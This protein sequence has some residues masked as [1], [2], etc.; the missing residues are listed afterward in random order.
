MNGVR[1]L[2]VVLLLEDDL[3]RL[4]KFAASLSLLVPR[5]EFI[6]WRTAA[7]FIESYRNTGH[8]LGLIALDHDL[9][10]ATET[11][12]DPGDGRQVAEFLALSEP[13]CPVLIH[14]S[15]VPAGNTMQFVLEPRGWSVERIYPIGADRIESS[16]LT[17]ARR[18]IEQAK[19]S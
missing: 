11:E 14:S 13:C 18:L 12:P 16:W 1:N 7:G 9:I 8:S 17:A 6:Y 19:A 10:P 3:E 5:V 4:E 15:N 2:R